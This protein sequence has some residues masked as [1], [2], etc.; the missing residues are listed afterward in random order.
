[1]A[2]NRPIQLCVAAAAVAVVV[3]CGGRGR[4]AAAHDDRSYPLSSYIFEAK[5]AQPATDLAEDARFIQ[6][7]HDAYATRGMRRSV[8]GVVVVH[9]HRH[10]HV[11]LLKHGTHYALYV[12]PGSWSV[13]ARRRPTAR[14]AREPRTQA[15][16]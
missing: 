12:R 15:R 10:P 6:R 2:L 9:E 3:R 11:L 8:D 5:E 13:R 1:M 14:H 4:Q 16:R 7:L